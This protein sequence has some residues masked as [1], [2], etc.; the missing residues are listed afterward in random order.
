MTSSAWCRRNFF[1]M[2][3]LQAIRTKCD[4][5][6]KRRMTRNAPGKTSPSSMTTTRQWETAATS[7]A[8]ITTGG[9]ATVIWTHP[10]VKRMRTVKEVKSNAI[11][12]SWGDMFFTLMKMLAVRSKD[13]NLPIMKNRWQSWQIFSNCWT[14]LVK[15]AI[16]SQSQSWWSWNVLSSHHLT[17]L[18][19]CLHNWARAFLQTIQKFL[20]SMKGYRH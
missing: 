11:H 8:S 16:Q 14:L 5:R 9:K 12:C 13:R 3:R 4:S 15:V 6:K 17:N 20:G 1:S 19:K 7:K 18:P 10:I 2:N